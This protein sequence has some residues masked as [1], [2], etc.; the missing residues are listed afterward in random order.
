MKERNKYLASYF[1]YVMKWHS[2]INSNALMFHLDVGSHSDIQW[3]L[4][5]SSSMTSHRQPCFSQF[6]T[7]E[8]FKTLF[9]KIPLL[10]LFLR[11]CMLPAFYPADSS[12]HPLSTTNLYKDC[13]LFSSFSWK[14]CATFCKRHVM[15]CTK[16]ILIRH[17]A[18]RPL[19][20]VQPFALF[21]SNLQFPVHCN[22]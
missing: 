13:I 11:S 22:L 9:S 1:A 10:Q 20:V 3:I 5:D 19:G 21:K 4:S 7:T 16:L 15:H 14:F 8:P 6:R 18:G 2:S 12:S 17:Q